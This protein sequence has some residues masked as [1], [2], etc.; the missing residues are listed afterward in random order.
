MKRPRLLLA[1]ILV[2]V[3]VLCVSL[4]VG[5]GPLW[6]SVMTK[7]VIV[8]SDDRYKLFEPG[9]RLVNSDSADPGFGPVTARGWLI[10]RRQWSEESRARQHGKKVL[11]YVSTGFKFMDGYY[12]ASRRMGRIT[13][14]RPDGTVVFQ[15]GNLSGETSHER[16]EPPWLWGVTDQTEPTAPWWG[17]E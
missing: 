2:S 5:E 10:L 17:K 13:R 3:T 4:W 9:V 12:Y 7:K 15:W 6:R 11:W 8:E 16:Q 14:W 1:I